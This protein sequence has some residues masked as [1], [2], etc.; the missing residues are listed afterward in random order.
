MKIIAYLPK[1]AQNFACNEFP[2]PAWI[3]SRGT[4]GA[5]VLAFLQKGLPSNGPKS[6][7]SQTVDDWRE[8]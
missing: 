8:I 1:Q 6:H 2:N 3:Y 5:T 4:L 7:L